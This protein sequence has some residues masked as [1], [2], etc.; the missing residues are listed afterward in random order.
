MRDAPSHLY[1]TETS[2]AEQAILTRLLARPIPHKYFDVR[3]LLARQLSLDLQ[4]FVW[5]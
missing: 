2:A 3:P 5:P 1:R 4:H